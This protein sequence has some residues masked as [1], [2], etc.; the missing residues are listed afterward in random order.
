MASTPLAYAPRTR[1]NASGCPS[2]RVRVRRQLT[3]QRNEERRATAWDAL[4]PQ[5]SAVILHD[6]AR[7]REPYPMATKLRI[8]MKASKQPK[9]PASIELRRVDSNAVVSNRKHDFFTRRVRSIHG[10]QRASDSDGKLDGV[11]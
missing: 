9:A 10:H 4:A 7:A 8:G 5:S 3:G 1:G 11:G 2:L 6:D